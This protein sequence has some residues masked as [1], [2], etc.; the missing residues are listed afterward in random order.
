[1][2]SEWLRMLCVVV[3]TESD[4]NGRVVMT[5]ARVVQILRLRIDKLLICTHT[6]VCMHIHMYR[7]VYIRTYYIAV[8][9]NN[10]HARLVIHVRY[11]NMLTRRAAI[12]W[13]LYGEWL[14]CDNKIVA[15]VSLMTL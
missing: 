15:C 5:A 1:M 11:K 2:R 7:F 14:Y 3:M 13:L 4:T 6:Y 9:I 8:F 12:G 10:L